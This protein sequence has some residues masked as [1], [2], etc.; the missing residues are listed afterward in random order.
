MLS[1]YGIVISIS[2]FSCLIAAEKIY[3]EKKKE[4]WDAGLYAVIAGIAGSRI[5]HVID[6]WQYYKESPVKIL[7]VWNGGLGIWGAVLGGALGIGIYSLVHKNSFLEITD[8]VATVLPLGQAIGRWGNY[9]NSELAGKETS[10]PWAIQGKHPL[11]FYE[12]VLNMIL[13]LLLVRFSKRNPAPGVLLS[14]YL[15]GYGIIRFFLEFL[16]VTPWKMG[17]LNVAQMVS[18]LSIGIALIIFI[19][20]RRK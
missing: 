5:Y 1:I 3:P 17:G 10:L 4:I 19:K 2:I 11:F 6:Y 7:E 12:S 15:A 8:I 13:F 9:F 20:G 18:I 14:I 16:R